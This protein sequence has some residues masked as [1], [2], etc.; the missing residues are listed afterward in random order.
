M[1]TLYCHPVKRYIIKNSVTFV[2]NL[3]AMGAREPCSQSNPTGRPNP[4][5]SKVICIDVKILIYHWPTAGSCLQCL[6]QE[7]MNDYQMYVHR[8]QSPMYCC[9]YIYHA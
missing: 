1:A 8:V 4:Q 6:M 2:Q 9:F 3:L 5:V 7:E